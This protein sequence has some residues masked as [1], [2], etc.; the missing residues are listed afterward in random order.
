MGW[1]QEWPSEERPLALFLDAVDRLESQSLTFGNGSNSDGANKNGSNDEWLQWLPVE[2]LGAWTRVTPHTSRMPPNLAL[3]DLALL[4]ALG[5]QIPTTHRIRKGI[6]SAEGEISPA[7]H[8]RATP[9]T[10]SSCHAGGNPGANLK[11]ISHRCH[12]REVALESELTRETIFLPLSCLQGGL[13]ST[14]AE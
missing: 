10:S 4:G 11:S 8:L 1:W 14:A 12:L 7:C 2:K 6:R 9:H 13:L 3:L 5:A